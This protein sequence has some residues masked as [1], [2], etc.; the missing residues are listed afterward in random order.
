MIQGTVETFFVKA[1]NWKK[2]SEKGNRKIRPGPLFQV[3]YGQIL[4][5][6]SGCLKDQLHS[7]KFIMTQWPSKN[8]PFCWLYGTVPICKKHQTQVILNQKY[9]DLLWDKLIPNIEF[10]PCSPSWPLPPISSEDWPV[11]A[12]VGVQHGNTWNSV[13]NNSRPETSFNFQILVVW[14][15][16]CLHID[17]KPVVLDVHV[18]SEVKNLLK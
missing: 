17:T 12:V 11:R 2:G 14:E 6:T 18:R 1:A 15:V 4:A 10:I 3:I 9:E 5:C 7:L 8:H 13:P 16:V